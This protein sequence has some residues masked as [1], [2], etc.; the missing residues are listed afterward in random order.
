MLSTVGAGTVED[1]PGTSE[2]NTPG[3][4]RHAGR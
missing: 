4:S 2:T 3:R 1:A